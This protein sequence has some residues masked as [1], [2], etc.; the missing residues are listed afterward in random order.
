[1]PLEQIALLTGSDP[2][3]INITDEEY[4]IHDTDLGS[5]FLYN[6]QLYIVFGDTFGPGGGDWSSNVLAISTDDDPSDG[7]TIDRFIED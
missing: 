7:I 3:S 2:L 4:G 5:T 1:M 6:D